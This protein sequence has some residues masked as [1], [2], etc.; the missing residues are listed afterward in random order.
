ME[1]ELSDFLSEELLQFCQSDD[2]EE[3]DGDFN[4]L[5]LQASELFERSLG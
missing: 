2:G 3:S 1:L 5:L 4:S